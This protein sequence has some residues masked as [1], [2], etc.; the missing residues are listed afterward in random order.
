MITKQRCQRI[1]DQ[2]VTYARG[3]ADGVEVTISGSNIATSRFA[4]NGMTQNQC[5]DQVTLSVRVLKNGRQSRQNTDNVSASGIISVVDK[6]INAALKLEKDPQLLSLPEPAQSIQV[7]RYHA[8]TARLSALRRAD[9]V[10]AMIDTAKQA[11]LEAAGVY[12]SGMWFT[13]IGNSNGLF[14]YHEESSVEGS[15]TAVAADSTGWAKAHST[16]I[17][18]FSAQA[19]ARQAVDAAIRSANPRDIPA[20]RYTVILPPTAVLDLLCF[21]WH[22][23]SGTSHTDKLSSLLNKMGQTVF[24]K[25]ITIMDDAYHPLQAGAPFDGEGLARSA[26]TLVE[27]G[28]LKNLVHGRRSAAKFGTAPTGHGLPE[29]NGEGEA[30]M[31]LVVA[32][33]N[34]SLEEMIRTTERGI[35]LSRV[36]YVRPVD[37]E[38]VLLTG[39]SRDGT[40]LVEG[41]EIAY[42]V[43]NLRFNVS[44]HELLRNVLQLGPPVR[45]AGEE[46]IPAVVPAMKVA[47]FNFTSTTKF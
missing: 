45:A 11:N 43:K 25:N 28:V 7:Q 13:A 5:P 36:W 26:I 31:N 2:A 41:G 40:F 33:G 39:M 9:A 3:K 6:A 14:Q 18:G 27:N 47:D 19:L 12:A 29:P 1:V 8:P 22:D 37:P 17:K 32:G 16:D 21:L 34:T 15:I 20:G 35:L 46:G 44:V 4:C 23:F 30:P 42:G 24:G 38:T 10:A